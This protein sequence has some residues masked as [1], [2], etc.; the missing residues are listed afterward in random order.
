[1]ITIVGV[2]NT[3]KSTLFN[4]LIGKRKALVHHDAGMTRDIYK[5]PLDIDGRKFHLQDSGGFFDDSDIITKEI[6]KRV[7]R[8]A[9]KSDLI[10]FMF[11]GKRDLLGYEKDLYLDILKIN[12]NIIPVINKVDNP[13]KFIPPAEIY[14]LKQDFLLIS[15]EHSDGLDELLE[16]IVKSIPGSAW[17]GDREDEPTRISIIGKP[18]VGKSSLIN[19]ILNDEYVIVSPL[20][21]TTRDSV[22]LEI[23][24]NNKTFIL[25]DNAGIRKLQKVKE[26]T[27]SAAVI[28]AEKDIKNADIIIFVIDISKKIDRNDLFIAQKILK[29]AKPVVVACN[30]WDL[31]LDQEK[32]DSFVRKLK[33][34]LNF[35]YFAPFLLTSAKSGKNIFQVIDKAEEINQKLTTKIKAT[36]LNELVQQILLEKRILTEGN[37]KFISKYVSIEAYRPFFLN[38]F[39]KGGERLKTSDEMWLK[40][41]VQQELG[42]EGIPIFFKI[43]ASKRRTNS[44]TN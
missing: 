44:G 16:R 41:R 36:H 14:A 34:R 27:E 40:K 1:M 3:G 18:N 2:P 43:T 24:R 32:A 7:F 4:K 5:K 22:D 6:N 20:P 9:E 38:F 21:G 12:S 17:T 33:A 19:R 25:V 13:S 29:S 15:A 35:F 26:D 10:I 8:E 42:L 31:V 28:R 39:A 23:K 11:D 37:K 30:K